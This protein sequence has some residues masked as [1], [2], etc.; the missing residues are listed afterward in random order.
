MGEWE[1]SGRGTRKSGFDEPCF[2]GCVS[3]PYSEGIGLDTLSFPR[4]RE[5]CVVLSALSVSRRKIFA[6]Q[7]YV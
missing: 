1:A 3:F 5:D 2:S 6:D 7:F 4:Q